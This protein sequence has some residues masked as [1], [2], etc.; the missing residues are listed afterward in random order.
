MGKSPVSIGFPDTIFPET[1]PLKNTQ[2]PGTFASHLFD[3]QPPGHCGQERPLTCDL[4]MWEN[5]GKE[6]FYDIHCFSTVMLIKHP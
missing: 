1:N 5:M 2:L 6:A 3:L 4:N